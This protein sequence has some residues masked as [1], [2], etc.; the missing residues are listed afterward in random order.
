MYDACRRKR[1]FPPSARCGS[2]GSSFHEQIHEGGDEK[3]SATAS[4][5]T[6]ANPC[7][8]TSC[9]ASP[10]ETDP[11]AGVVVTL[12]LTHLLASMSK[13]ALCHHVIRSIKELLRDDFSVLH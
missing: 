2:G 12:Q 10:S 1:D 11:G 5:L 3:I 9:A 7:A 8:R 6:M 13:T 4:A